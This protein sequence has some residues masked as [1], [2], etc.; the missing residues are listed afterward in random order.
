MSELKKRLLNNID[1]KLLALAMAII[2]WFY[3]SSEYNISA[4]RYYDIEVRAINLN[5]NLSIKDIR[6]KISVGIEGPQNTLENLSSQKIIGTIDLQNIK[7]PGDYQIEADVIIPKNTNITRIIPN[8]IMVE[9]EEILEKEYPVEYNLIGLPERGYSLED[10]PEITPSE[11]TVVG[12]NSLLEQIEQVKIDIDISSIKDDSKSEETVYVYNKNKEEIKNLKV[13]PE[14]V[15]VSIEVGE[16]YPEKTLPIKPRIIGKPAP[17]YYISKI[18]ATPS[19]IRVYGNYSKIRN[20]DFLE[21]IPIDVNGISK[22]LTVKIPPIITEGVYLI[23]EQETLI[24]VRI[25][26]EEKEEERLFDNIIINKREA[27]PFL[28]YK[29]NPEKVDIRI[30]GKYDD[31]KNITEDDIKVF[32]NLSDT[33]TERAKVEVELPPGINLIQIIPEEVD[34]AI[35]Q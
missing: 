28:S 32:V 21:T 7:E 31:M 26:V 30:S 23:D 16:G 1:I 15:F 33:E 19:Y 27:S 13:K 24:E 11:V 29:L 8:N 34:I 17:E 5:D 3:I 2:L 25:Q 6:D 12:P 22:T 20:L 4:E 35:K 14:K 9:V 10:L 18:E